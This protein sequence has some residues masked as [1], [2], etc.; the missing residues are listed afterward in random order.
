VGLDGYAEGGTVYWRQQSMGASQSLMRTAAMRRPI[1]EAEGQLWVACGSTR[2]TAD[3]LGDSRNRAAGNRVLA[4]GSLRCI[5]V[6]DVARPDDDN[7]PHCS[8]SDGI[9]SQQLTEN[10]REVPRPQT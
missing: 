4:T 6:T 9:G 10:L 1:C 8:R 7:A 5:A 2:T 3:R